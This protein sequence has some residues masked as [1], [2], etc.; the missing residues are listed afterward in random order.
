MHLIGP[1][2]QNQRSSH[3]NDFIIFIIEYEAWILL[4]R[5]II[6]EV[7]ASLW[8]RRNIRAGTMLVLV[9]GS[10]KSEGRPGNREMFS[11]MC[12]KHHNKDTIKPSAP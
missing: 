12:Q 8:S 9:L 2:P 3:L 7:V 1:P 10:L 11:F 6:F 4:F 5:G